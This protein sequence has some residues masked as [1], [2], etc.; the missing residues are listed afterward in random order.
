[1]LTVVHVVNQ[2]FAGLGGEEKADIPVG[3]AEGAVGVARAFQAQLGDQASVV[4]TVYFGD[5]YFH[6][7]LE[8]AKEAILREVCSRKPQ[9]VVAGP[10]FNA[11]RYGLACVEISQM[12]SENLELPCVTA[13]HPANPAVL[14][15]REHH[16]L[17]SFLLPSSETAVGM[18]Q[19]LASIARFVLRVGMGVEIGPAEKEGYIARGV[20]R[21]EKADRPGAKRAIDM[22][23]KRLKGRPITTEIPVEAWDGVKFAHPVSDLSSATIAVITTS[24]VVPWGNP[25]GFKIFRNTFWRKYDIA[26]LSTMEPGRWEAIH[27]G[28]NVSYM[29]QNPHYGM[30][31]DVLRSL[32][33]D[34][35]IGRL[36]PSYYVVPGNQGSP[37]VMRRIGQELAADLHREGIDGVLLVS[38]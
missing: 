1:M 33:A 14:A 26:R 2:F 29:N 21:M 8:Q 32:E 16:N 27:G 6:E 38:T 37:S 5:N 24:G 23:L 20:R 10:A 35:T 34:K 18:A 15:Y 12:I 13:M 28:Y 19:A 22:L 25:D 11:G 31:L 36:Y 9:V 30:P 7:H 4:A 17:K 3:V